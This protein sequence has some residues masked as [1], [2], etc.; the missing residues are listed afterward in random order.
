MLMFK[1]QQSP[2]SSDAATTTRASSIVGRHD[3][4]NNNNILSSPGIINPVY[5][6]YS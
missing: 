6:R 2:V 4:A 1:G 3:N 5:D